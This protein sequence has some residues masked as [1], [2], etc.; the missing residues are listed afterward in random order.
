RV[1]IT[2]TN[3]IVQV[4]EVQS[5]TSLGGGS[6]LGL[7]FGLGTGDLVEVRVRWPDGVEEIVLP[8]RDR[9]NVVERL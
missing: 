4:R 7:H 2:D 1:T 3:G 9:W 8:T 6:D 5:G